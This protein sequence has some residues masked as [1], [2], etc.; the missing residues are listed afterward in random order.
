MQ[1]RVTPFPHPTH[2]IV[3]GSREIDHAKGCTILILLSTTFAGIL[4]Q[5]VLP[6]RQAPNSYYPLTE[7]P[8]ALH[9]PSP[10]PPR[11]HLIPLITIEITIESELVAR[12]SFENSRL[13][14]K[15]RQ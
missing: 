3:C 7:S 9:L 8:L 1:P 5:N 14:T 2:L 4:M 11:G 15:R 13:V 6:G 10:L 12:F